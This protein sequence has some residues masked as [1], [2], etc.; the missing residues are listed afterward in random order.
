MVEFYHKVFNIGKQET[1]YRDVG[2]NKHGRMVTESYTEYSQLTLKPDWKE[3][4]IAHVLKY[5]EQ[6]KAQFIR[7][8]V[9]TFEKITLPIKSFKQLELRVNYG[10]FQ[11]EYKFE[12]ENGSSFILKTQAIVAG[13]HNIQIMHLR[14]LVDYVNATLA[15]GS[16]VSNPS[17]ANIILNFS[18]KAE[19][20]KLT[21]PYL[22]VE[23]AGSL[24]QIIEALY[25]FCKGNY[26]FKNVRKYDSKDDVS[27][28]FEYD[29][30][31][32]DYKTRTWK[33]GFALKKDLSLEDAKKKAV[34]FLDENQAE[35][36]KEFKE[37]GAVKEEKE[38]I[39]GNYHFDNGMGSFTSITVF[40]LDRNLMATDKY[41]TVLVEVRA[42]DKNKVTHIQR[43]PLKTYPIEQ[44]E[45]FMADLKERGARKLEKGGD[46]SDY[47]KVASASSRFKP[48]ETIFFNPPLVGKNGAK[49]TSYTWRY[50]WMEDWD[51]FKGETV[52]KRV[53]DWNEMEISA[54][55]GRGIVHQYTVEM[56]DGTNK[57]VSAESVPVLLGYVDRKELKSFP[58]LVTASKTLAKQQM[59][60]A[61]MEAQEKEYNELQSKFEKEPKPE[62]IETEYGGLPFVRRMNIDKDGDDSSI[63]YFSMGDATFSQG[64]PYN[65]STG[66]YTKI[67][68]PT[69]DTIDYLQQYWV[70]NRL[71]EAGVK[72]PYGLYDLRNRIE[73]QKRKLSQILAQK[74]TMEH[75]GSVTMDREQSLAK[76]AQEQGV[77][78]HYLKNNRKHIPIPE[79]L[80]H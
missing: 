18:D 20:Q 56:P 77:S 39:G 24:M 37:G 2:L 22:L 60:L 70:S 26:N 30:Y 66:K 4:V 8:I 42:V 73:R 57:T 11:G 10:G 25:K 1:K 55:T 49:L 72:R 9:V 48:K 54:D 41:F 51:N 71:K 28:S 61:I 36:P 6:L 50:E 16:K 15:D 23:N 17:L 35:K 13:G 19:T 33:H 52:N 27:L 43:K 46:V 74:D 14:Y 5:I 76:M 67:H 44:Y 63:T 79:A 62:I 69:K 68:T 65:Y 53:S 59:Q 45:A 29:R 80:R 47:S 58:N 32:K 21:N 38:E 31:A 3:T 7:S 34:L 12:F 40:P 78:L 64:N 75:G